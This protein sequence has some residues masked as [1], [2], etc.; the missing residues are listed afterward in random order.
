M[1]CR[2]RNRARVLPWVAGLVLL[3]VGL[4]WIFRAELALLGGMTRLL[5]EQTIVHNFQ[6]MDELLDTRTIEAGGQV[7]TFE[8]GEFELPASFVYGGEPRDT[9]AF[10]EEVQT[11]GLLVLHEDRIL[12]E[13]Y[14]HGHGP[15]GRHLAWSVS[16]SFTSA[17]VGIAVHEGD[18]RDI[19]QPVT[20]YLPELQGSGYDGVSIKDVL[21]MSSGVRFDEDYGDPLS[22]INRMGPVMAVGDLLD[23]AAGLER[24]REPGTFNHYVS[25]DTQVLGEIVVRAT[26]R[27]LADYT[28]EKLWKPLGMEQPGYWILDGTGTEWAFGGLNASLRDF[29]RFGWLYL[30]EGNRHGKQI[31]PRA[32][33]RASV[34]ATEAHL[35]PG[36]EGSQAMGYGY[37]WWLPWDSHGDF[38]G[39]GIYGQHLYVDPRANLVIVRNAVD[40]NYLRNGFENTQVGL[41]LYRAIAAELSSR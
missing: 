27:D 12:L 3:A 22:D 13:R 36:R 40:L 32:W 20:D 21:Q 14:A 35:L 5:D 2:R 7:L 29:A 15:E 17:L 19:A 16:K 25:V 1:V 33:A 41:A 9:E 23:F 8:R 24:E 4:L 39:L 34:T 6:H 38:M 10:L 18:I 30:N 11:T 31:V 26:G 28:S 37:Q